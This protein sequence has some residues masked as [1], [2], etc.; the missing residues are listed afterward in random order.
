MKNE[1]VFH[2][3]EFVDSDG[4]A[5]TDIEVIV[6]MD[7]DIRESPTCQNAGTSHRRE[8]MQMNRKVSRRGAK[9]VRTQPVLDCVTRSLIENGIPLTQRN[10]IEFAYGGKSTHFVRSSRFQPFRG[11]GDTFR[12]KLGASLHASFRGTKAQP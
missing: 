10:W 5:Y 8:G 1:I 2:V 12:N 9:R 7:G 6:E 3:P 11:P 4:I